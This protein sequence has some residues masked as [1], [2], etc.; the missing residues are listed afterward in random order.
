MP[1]KLRASRPNDGSIYYRELPVRV[2]CG[3][4]GLKKRFA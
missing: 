1:T 3:L 2:Y 4:P